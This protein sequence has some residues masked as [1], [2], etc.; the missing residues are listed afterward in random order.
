ML[1]V[2]NLNIEVNGNLLIKNLGLS[3]AKGSCICFYSSTGSGKTTLIDTLLGEKEYAFK[4]I[5][6]N[7]VSIGDAL[8]VYRALIL[9][10]PYHMLLDKELSVFQNLKFFASMY[11]MESEIEAAVSYLKLEKYLKSKVTTLSYKVQKR[12]NLSRLLLSPAVLWLLDEPFLELDDESS[13][14]LQTLIKSRCYQ[15]GIVI[16][17]AMRPIHLENFELINISLDDFR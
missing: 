13:D 15:N 9:H 2:D 3:M 6:Y 14:M 17:T 8:G 10:M 12:L 4:N 11:T 7:G 5:S 16:L 1:A